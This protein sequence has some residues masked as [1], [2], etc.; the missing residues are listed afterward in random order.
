MSAFF[1]RNPTKPLTITILFVALVALVA[2]A[3]NL[4]NTDLSGGGG[5]VRILSEPFE[6][7][8]NETEA[9]PPREFST[10]IFIYTFIGLGIIF[11]F[12]ALRYPRH[13]G[14]TL[15]FCLAIVA[16]FYYF[17]PDDIEIEPPTITAPEG[18]DAGEQLPE[19]PVIGRPD[20]VDNP[21]LWFDWLL[22]LGVFGIIGVIALAIF[23][24][25][26]T[27]TPVSD[28]SLEQIA[29]EAQNTIVNIQSGF[30][31]KDAILNCYAKM[32]NTLSRERGITLQHTMTPREFEY[33]LLNK[34]LPS[35]PVSRLTRLFETVRY[36]SDR[37][38][39]RERRE[40]VSCLSEI[41]EAV[42][43]VQ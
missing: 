33:Q 39:E 41:V 40:A 20:F 10:D 23:R 32:V 5:Q 15:L 43:T 11:L 29:H 18:L 28:T 25:Y 21:P 13:F 14:P 42:A 38:G 31:L 30:E 12:A 4:I 35:Q 36:G 34:G 2:L 37:L 19:P 6:P 3:A 1:G 26:G 8:E 17:A 9:E 24:R 7:V 16:L 27:V 22:R